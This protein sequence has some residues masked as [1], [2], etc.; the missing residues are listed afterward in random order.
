MKFQDIPAHILS[1]RVKPT[2]NF[3]ALQEQPVFSVDTRPSRVDEFEIRLKDTVVFVRPVLAADIRRLN[4]DLASGRALL[5][6]LASPARDG[7]VELQIAFFT[8]DCLEMGDVDI[9]VDEYVEDGLRKARYDFKGERLYEKLD[10]LCC[11]RQDENAFFFLTAGPAID[12]ELKPGAEGSPQAAGAEPTRESSF[13]ITGDGIR[14]VATEKAVPGGNSIFIATRLTG[15][16]NT[17]DR[18]LRLAKGK[19][20]FLDWTR[21][22]Q[23]QVLAKAQM[24]AL[25]QDDGS[26]LKKWDEFGEVE[27][28]LLLKQARAVG[29]LQF[30]DMEQRR[31]GTVTVRIVDASDSAITILTENKVPEL[32]LVDEL[33]DYLLNE[34]LSFKEF[35]K[36]IKS[37]ADFE[38]KIEERFVQSKEWAS[39][40]VISFDKE[41]RSLALKTETLHSAFG[42]LILSLKGDVTQI[43][44]RMAARQAILEGRS[45]NPQLGLLIEE[46][47]QIAQ[48]RE[49][50]KIPPLT[51]FVRKKVFRN[52][53]TLMQETAIKVAL[54]T[55]D[56]ALIQGPPGTGKT[57][58]IAA[59]LERLNEMA[60][61]R[62]ARVKGQ[63]LLTGFQHDAVENMIERLSLNSLPVPKFGKR[64]GAAEDDY[65]TFERNLEDWC[66]NLAA[67]LR[68]RN[69]Q[70]AEVEQEREIKNLFLQYVQA[71][72]RPLAAHLVRKITALGI[73]VLGEDDARRADNLEK[74]LAREE[75]L[76]VDSGQWLDAAR[77]LRVRFESFADDGAERAVDALDDLSDVLK[78]NERK[79]LDEASLWRSEDG[80]PSFLEE[81]RA[82][83]R[84]L[85]VRFT[86]PP[87]FRVDKQN[88][89][90]IA[91]AERAIQ[92]IKNV[93]HSAKDKKSA[94]LVEFL[95]ELE[96]NPYGMMDAVSDY[97]FAF[98]ATCQQSVNRGMQMQKGI[99]GRDVSENLKGMEYE[100]VIVDEAARVSPRDLMVA[101]AQ[102]KRIILVGDHRQLPHIIDEEVARQMEE[103]E[104]GQNENDWLKKSMFQYLF[105][106]RLKA[107]ED[108]DRFPRRVTLD[109][110]Y[111]MHPLLGSF[112]S[113]NFY[114]RFDPSE[115]FESG[116]PASDFAHTLSGTH[117]K[118]VVWFDVPA[119]KGG[120]Q[121]NG[122]SWTRPAEATV[123][124]RQLQAWMR[125]DAGK[126]LSFGVISFYKAQADI[127]REQLKR[128]LGGIANDDKKLRVG[129]VDSFQG[130]EFD[131]VFLSMV[132][133]LPQN[134]KPKSD[135][136]EKQA[137]GLFGHLCLY[138]RLNVAMSRQK[139]LLVVVGDA[140]AL[141]NQLAED[142]V[143]GL[144]DFLRLC[145]SEGVV[146]P[147]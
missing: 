80:P 13:C 130:M 30:T 76:N 34:L 147:C 124:A 138:N 132:R 68:E 47:G 72:T 135:N 37:A 3:S 44:R 62:G 12:E 109:K 111:R 70:L 104:T 100:Y 139:K 94:A 145:K 115:K 131:V 50:Q 26:Y 29:T 32:E 22:G 60:D 114:E 45:A 39:F 74:T 24:A 85:L 25:T 51:A 10:H 65:S 121:R 73:S 28:E 4:T 144:V 54:N 123:I 43:E 98:A 142:Y 38:K 6:Q 126:Y 17:S 15:R 116:R 84:R 117:E 77:R 101:M 81:L 88:D 11:F 57:T 143:P 19:L 35:E 63:I 16:R 87:V 71:P 140:G 46:H 105:S 118:P 97:S 127:I 125:S 89:E 75:R 41:T 31:D 112:I 27:G 134:W 52:D 86:N 119:A 83:K 82:L 79:L 96:S 128:E 59:I 141:Q 67:E 136:S 90:V 137:R 108:G 1:I 129:T 95:A 92:R 146:L 122:T 56:I 58:V 66:S 102:G 99:T 8:G 61:K 106:D 5:A 107:L 23:V 49:P 14:F 36:G 69:P 53:P 7:S 78:E 33:P 93:G 64:S 55:P 42:T 133:T 2:T 9:G 21:V 113:R 18:A 48:I 110:Q 20:R 91:L 40:A 120:H 103:G